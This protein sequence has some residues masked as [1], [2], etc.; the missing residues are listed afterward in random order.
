MFSEPAPEAPVP[1]QSGGRRLLPVEQGADFRQPPGETAPARPDIRSPPAA[2]PSQ[3]RTAISERYHHGLRH[4][5]DQ[6][7]T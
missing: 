5:Q 6:L 1:A 2:S 7:T 4:V 3:T